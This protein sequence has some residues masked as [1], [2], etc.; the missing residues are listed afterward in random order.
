M[1][2]KELISLSLITGSL[3]MLAVACTGSKPNPAGAPGPVGT[4]GGSTPSTPTPPPTVIETN[5]LAGQWQAPS[6][7]M[8]TISPNGSITIGNGSNIR[9]TITLGNIRPRACE[10]GEN[11]AGIADM[12]IT[13]PNGQQG[14]Q[15]ETNEIAYSIRENALTLV[16]DGTGY[17]YNRPGQVQAQP[18]QNEEQ[19]GNVSPFETH[20]LTGR[21]VLTSNND[22]IIISATGSA[23]NENRAIFTLSNLR[24]GVR[25]PGE[26]SAGTVDMRQQ[27]GQTQEIRYSV[28]GD[29]LILTIDGHRYDHVRDNPGEAPPIQ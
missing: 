26:D 23:T 18:D 2:L 20:G 28:Q 1:K 21:W 14:P 27:S 12:T 13:A 16:I 5:G 17:H 11:F 3:A 10:P 24:P 19:Q 9:N 22:V 8:M 7:E 6:G 4:G 15:T 25:E 29:H